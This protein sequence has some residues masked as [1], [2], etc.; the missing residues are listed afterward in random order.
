MPKQL[1]EIKD[2]VTMVR[3]RKDIKQIRIKKTNK[4]TKFKVRTGYV[5]RVAQRHSTIFY[6]HLAI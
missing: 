1:K 2:F 6:R 4:I 5:S 3:S